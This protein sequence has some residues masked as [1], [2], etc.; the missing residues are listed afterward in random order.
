M[1]FYVQ[2]EPLGFQTLTVSSAAVG[3][4]RPTE[5]AVSG[6]T[7]PVNAN[8]AYITV[9]TNAVRWRDDGTDPTAG[10][11]S[12]VA[13]GAT[14]IYDGDLSTIKFIRQSADATLTI[15]YYRA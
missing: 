6:A 12:P 14:L 8:Y 10:V 5:A 15:A 7:K 3:L 13:A 11:G 1:S 2:K 4:T 9:E